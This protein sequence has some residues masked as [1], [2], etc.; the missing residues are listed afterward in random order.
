MELGS[1]V[2]FLEN[3]SIL[4]TGA[5]SFLAE[6]TNI[7]IFCGEDTQDSTK[8]EEAFSSSK[9]SRYQVSHPTPS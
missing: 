9:S 5:T 6:N 4:V 3:K 2:E 1:I 8:R 7:W